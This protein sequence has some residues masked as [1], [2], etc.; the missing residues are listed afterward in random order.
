MNTFRSRSR[1]RGDVQESSEAAS[2]AEA[3]ADPARETGG[4]GVPEEEEERGRVL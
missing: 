4:R 2:V 1:E 3:A